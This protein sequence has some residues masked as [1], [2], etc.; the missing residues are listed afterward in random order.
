MINDKFN[1]FIQITKELNKIK[2][3]PLLMGSVGLEMITARSWHA[4]DLDIHVPG[5][6]RAWEISPELN[7]YQWND[8]VTL[9]NSL[10][11]ELIDLHEHEFSK[12]NFSVEFGIIDTL[13]TFAGI[14]LD[15]LELQQTENAKYYLLNARQ[16]L[17]VYEASSK[18]SYRNNHNDSKDFAKIE[19]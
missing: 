2:I 1:E 8:I 3:I 15:D 17:K 19:Y 6:K 18:D 14:Q 16:Y 5:D 7:V 11:Y 4:Q 13:P 12:N 10:G 9:M